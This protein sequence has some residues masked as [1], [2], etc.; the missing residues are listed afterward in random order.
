MTIQKV[1]HNILWLVAGDGSLVGVT[2][3]REHEVV[4]WHVHQIGGSG[5]VESV[6]CIPAIDGKYDDLYLVVKR[7]INS[8]TKRY[9]ERLG[10]LPD[11]STSSDLSSGY[12]VDAGIVL[13]NGTSMNTAT[14]TGLSH[15][16]TATVQA[17]V[18]GIYV[19][20]KIPSSGSITLAYLATKVHVGFGYE[21]V[22]GILDPEGG[23]QA[24]TSQGKKKRV[25]EVVARVEN[26]MH[27]KT[28]SPTGR[29]NAYMTL[30]A[31]DDPTALDRRLIIPVPVINAPGTGI[32]PTSE[33]VRLETG[34]ITFAIE[35]SYDDG[36]RF[37]IVQDEPYP[38]NL[39]SLMPKLNTNE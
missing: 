5:L 20:T 35:G 18:D 30:S 38:I 21:C 17:V 1:P 25:N 23:S 22:V 26:S 32:R 16:N 15:L 14:V 34:D 24:G 10:R 36:G 12:W 6:C 4:G 31:V 28:A 11:P 29:T 13:N 37:E 2:Y 39:V 7:T 33:T 3:E 9:V 19:G 27:F 8:S